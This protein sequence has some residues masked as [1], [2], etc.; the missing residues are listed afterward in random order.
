MPWKLNFAHIH[1]L[2]FVANFRIGHVISG[3]VAGLFSLCQL[4]FCVVIAAAAFCR[5]TR[6]FTLGFGSTVLK[7]N[8]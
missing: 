5:A 1:V 4:S 7:P 2:F 3:V 8:L 6:P